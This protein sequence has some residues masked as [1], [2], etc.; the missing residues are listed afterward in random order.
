MNYLRFVRT[1]VARAGWADYALLAM[2]LTVGALLSGWNGV[3]IIWGFT[4]AA[5]ISAYGK[6]IE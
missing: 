4:V 6:V 5:T 1:M 3:A 2:W